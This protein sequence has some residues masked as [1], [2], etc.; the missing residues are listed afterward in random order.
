M[1][2]AEA[3]LAR[4]VD[5]AGL[6]PPAALDM[7]RAVTNY[8][9]YL[10]GDHAWMLGN[11]VVPAGRLVE[12]A[13][14]FER[15]AGS[16][17]EL[18]WTLSVVCASED[19]PAIE[20]FQEG[21]AF[22]AGLEVKA[23]NASEA[24]AMLSALPT[25]R[26]RYLE[27]PAAAA[28]KVLP[29]LVAAGARAKLRTGGLTAD[30]IPSVESVAQFFLACAKARVAFK[31]TAGLHHAVRSERA[32]TY[33]EGSPRAKMHGFVNV[34]LAAALAFYGAGETALLATLHETDVAAFRLDG[35]LIAWHDHTMTTEQLER[36]HAEFAIGFGSCSFTEPIEALKAM[37]W[38]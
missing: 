24:E 38:L 11:F 20:E 28:E 8:Q 27:F 17:Q 31:A 4:V 21:A 19:L 13:S 30:A 14:A 29:V 18:P 3:L 16:E 33:Q 26:A 7:E 5:Y 10:V 6:F 12:F 1:S 2:A 22:I 34:F 32:L 37:A 15:V 9:K 25:G 35:D 23:A 36:V